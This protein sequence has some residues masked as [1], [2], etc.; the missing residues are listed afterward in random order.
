MA[1]NLVVNDIL[2][3]RYATFANGQAGLN[4]VHYLVTA[5]GVLPGTDIDMAGA[6]DTVVAPLYKAALP[7]N[8]QYYGVSVQRIRPLPVAAAV[9]SNLFTGQGNQLGGGLPGQV[10]GIAKVSTAVSGARGRG[11]I[12]FPFP[13]L[14]FTDTTTNVP[15]IAAIA[16]YTNLADEILTPFNSNI[17]GR[18]ATMVPILFHRAD[19]TS[20]PVTGFVVRPRWAT[21]TRRGNYGRPNLYP[22][23]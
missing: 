3:V 6:V 22:P 16:A 8:A 15:T 23:L 19:A 12:Y 18:S 20:S 5:V 11:R 17:G 9:I 2:T 1:S 14:G 21:Q 13:P 4:I 10:S 7:S